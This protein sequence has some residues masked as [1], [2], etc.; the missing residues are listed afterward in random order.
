ML[1]NIKNP[2]HDVPLKTHE[3]K[4]EAR[5]K[6]SEEYENKVDLEMCRKVSGGASVFVEKFF[7]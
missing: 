7:S 6:K 1:G 4:C 5:E 2:T 3:W